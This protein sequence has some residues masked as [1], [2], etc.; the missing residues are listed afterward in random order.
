MSLESESGMDRLEFL[1]EKVKI[2]KKNLIFWEKMLTSEVIIRSGNVYN[3]P[4]KNE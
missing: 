4:K 1:Q 2:A 3:T